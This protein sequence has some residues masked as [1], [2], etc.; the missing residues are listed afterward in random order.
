MSRWKMVRQRERPKSERLISHLKG[1]LLG[2]DW[3]SQEECVQPAPIPIQFCAEG[4]FLNT[5]NRSEHNTYKQEN[6]MMSQC[7]FCCWIVAELFYD[8][9][10]F[11][12]ICLN[13]YCGSLQ[14]KA[15]AKCIHVI[16]AEAQIKISQ[17]QVLRFL[18]SG[19]ALN[20]ISTDT[21]TKQ[22]E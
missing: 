2:C 10:W 22:H 9:I 21:S 7:V 18:H 12:G 13:V 8:F 16:V 14:I 11:S 6:K 3:L 20:R 5:D 19:M 17:S 15:S 4:I 1:S